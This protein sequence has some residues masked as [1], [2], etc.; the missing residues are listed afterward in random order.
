MTPEPNGGDELLM[1]DPVAREV[2]EKYFKPSPP[3][4]RPYWRLG[5]P[6]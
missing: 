5:P 3:V 6:R 4:V 1:A 2:V